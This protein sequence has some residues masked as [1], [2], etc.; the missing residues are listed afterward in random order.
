VAVLQPVHQHRPHQ[1]PFVSD[2]AHRHRHLQLRHRNTV[3]HR[4]LG[5]GHLGPLLD[6]MHNPAHLPLEWQS[7]PGAEAE[8][9]NVIVE[10]VL[11][12]PDADLDPLERRHVALEEEPLG[13]IE[14]DVFPAA[15]G[16]SCS[17]A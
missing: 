16:E 17:S 12:E 6:R 2:S 15:P 3:A 7:R 1:H 8:V 4:N 13:D 14:G 9:T 11:P 5:D 10:P